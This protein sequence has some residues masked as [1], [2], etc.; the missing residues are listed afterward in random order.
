[1][2]QLH[3]LE[4]GPEVPPPEPRPEGSGLWDDWS[5]AVRTIAASEV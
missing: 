5:E 3:E 2:R 4:L 1:V